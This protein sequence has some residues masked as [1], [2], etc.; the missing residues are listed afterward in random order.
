MNNRIASITLGFFCSMLLSHTA[1]A[2]ESSVKLHEVVVTA[3]KTEQDPQDL[4]QSVTVIT[5]DEIRKSGARTA[6]EVIARTTSVEVNDYGGDG[7]LANISIRGSLYQQVLVL[8][9]GK[10]LNSAGAGGFDMSDLPVPLD[11]I[12]R[13]EIVRGPSSAL[14]GADALGGVVNIITKK[15]AALESSITSAGGS[16][17][18]WT[19]G[20][21]N[22][23]KIGNIYYSLSANE[24]RY[25]GYRINSDLTKTTAGATLGYEFSKDSSLEAALN[26]VEKAIGVPGSIQFPTPLAREWDRNIIEALT[27][28]ARFSKELDVR[29]SVYENRDKILYKDPDTFFPQD[30]RNISTTDNVELQ[31][32]W[33]VNSWNLLTLGVDARADHL[34]SGGTGG[35]GEHSDSLIA[36]YIQDEISIGQPFILILGGR[37]DDNSVYG[38]QFSPKASARYLIDSTGTTF[39]ASIGKAYRAPTLND[40]FWAFDG[41]EE[42]NPNLKPETSVEYEGSVEQSLGKGRM[43]KFTVFERDVKDMIVWEMNP[44]TFIFSPVNIG[45]ARISGFEAEAKFTFFNAVTWG[46]NYTYMAPKDEVTGGY[47]PG[48]PED[49]LKSYVNITFPTKT[50]FYI[51]GRFVK[52]YVQP[53]PAVNPTGQY[54]VVDAKISQP[55]TIGSYLKTD[56]YAG[57]KNLTNRSYQ[58]IGG[59]PMPPTEVYGG[60]TVKF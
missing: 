29:I 58:V 32:N 15:P 38:G 17:G 21:N 40:L 11:K 16:Y 46:V 60:L 59:Y 14:Y 57:I 49:M 50:N 39:R 9:D 8:L 12:D 7:Q 34:E 55:L 52:N 53:A 48:V 51:E 28:K 6:A 44:S 43:V 33:L 24:E 26:Y 20:A 10:R 13:I 27:Y 1:L 19:L 35:A 36:G 18:Y 54:G 45:K 31:A 56:L 41:F 25:G 47:V 2:D 23:S 3:T 37:Y 30:S 42:G 4:T 22:S 5:A